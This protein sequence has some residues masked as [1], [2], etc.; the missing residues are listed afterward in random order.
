M[1]FIARGRRRRDPLA[2]GALVASTNA[3][4]S[5]TDALIASLTLRLSEGLSRASSCIAL[6]SGAP[7]AGCYTP[8][9]ERFL[10]VNAERA[11]DTAASRL[12]S[13]PTGR[14]QTTQT[15]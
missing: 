3:F 4:H 15:R 8:G 14:R 2:T 5:G 12:V 13:S 6:P 11:V 10:C 9:H 1:Y 7:C